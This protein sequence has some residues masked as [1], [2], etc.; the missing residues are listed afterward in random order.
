MPF[1]QVTLTTENRTVDT[2]RVLVNGQ[3]QIVS[4]Q[5]DLFVKCMVSEL[6]SQFESSGGGGWKERVIGKLTLLRSQHLILS[7]IT[8]LKTISYNCYQVSVIIVIYPIWIAST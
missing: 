1:L 4:H 2:L 6:L 7:L 5:R 3:T 8:T